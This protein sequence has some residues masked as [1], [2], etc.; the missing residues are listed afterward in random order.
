[1]SSKKTLQT[2]IPS[3]GRLVTRFFPYL[4]QQ[5]SWLGL[6]MLAITADV[7]LR[8]LEPWPLKLIFDYVL[9][10]NEPPLPFFAP[11]SPLT[12]LTLCILGIVAMTGLRA[13]SA[14]WSTVSLAIASS[15]VMIQVRDQLYRHLQ[16]LSLTYHHQSRSGDLIVRI[17]SD[18]SRLQEILIT[19]TLPLIVSLM[20]LLGTVGVMFWVDRDLT[21]LS[22][23]TFPLFILASQRLSQRIRLASVKQRQEEG[24]V[25]ATASEALGAIKLIQALSLENA[26]AEVFSQQNQRSLQQSVHTQQLSASLERVVDGIIALGMAMVLWYGSWLVLRDA[27]TPGDVIVFLTY[28]KNSF[29]PIQNFAKYTG[30]LAKAAASGERILNI[31]DETPQIQDLPQAIVAPTLTRTLQFKQ[32]SF[33]YSASQNI[34]KEINFTVK[35]G[36][37]VAIVGQ[38]GSGKSTL[39]SLLLRLYDPMSGS[40]L[41][42]GQDIRHYTLNS[43]RSQISV[44]LQESLLFAATIKENIAYGMVSVTD[45][46]IIAAA[47]LANAHDFIEKLPQKYDTVIGERGATLSGGQRQRI[48]IARAAI[49]QTPILILDEPTTGLDQ[50]NAQVVIEALQRL[51]HQRTTFLITHDLT[52]ATQAD[53][54]LYL[55]NGK[56][57]EQGTHW[58]LLQ[59]KGRYAQLY[60]IQCQKESEVIYLPSGEETAN[61]E[62]LIGNGFRHF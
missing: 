36:Q 30:R 13:F 32:V 39:M 24:F 12:L 3:L 15:R 6:A 4:Q 18:T 44:V 53:V 58:E 17:S 28:L 45:E 26:F 60:S 47:K 33:G 40:I 38:S 14:Y 50:E 25:A 62:Q 7:V 56:I 11:L 48:A 55:E 41:M 9:L 1:M 10:K 2:T 8:I 37:F 46:E 27:L 57:L 31:L 34:L 19:A 21:L 61:R 35:S 22:L 43:W 49:R 5:K 52:L 51:A 16:Q 42:D 20:T 23:L 54:I 59:Q 29:K